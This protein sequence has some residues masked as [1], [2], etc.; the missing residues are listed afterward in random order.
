MVGPVKAD[1]AEEIV[2][3]AMKNPLAWDS[4]N[5]KGDAALEPEFG[6]IIERLVVEHP[7]AEYERLEKALRVGEGR[8]EHGTVA[9]HLDDA[10]HNARRAHR[11]WQAAILERRRWEMDN[12]VVFSAMRS[13]ATRSLQHEKEQGTRT[14]Q[15]TDADVEARIASLFPDEWRKQEVQRARVKSMVDSMQNLTE[16]WASRCRSLQTI[17]GKQR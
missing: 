4:A 6:A 15:I 7:L 11:L 2:E 14:K 3:R 16:L 12:D 1:P 10:E 17:H 5:R 9:K 13:E 8:A